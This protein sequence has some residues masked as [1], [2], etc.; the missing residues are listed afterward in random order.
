[1][2]TMILLLVS[3]VLGMAVLGQAQQPALHPEC[4]VQLGQALNRMGQ[5]Q[6]LA[7]EDREALILYFQGELRKVM[8]ERDDLRKQVDE[9]KKVK[10]SG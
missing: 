3:L 8:Q 1:M 7:R 6:T 9:S 5:Q 2:S 4:Q 10:E